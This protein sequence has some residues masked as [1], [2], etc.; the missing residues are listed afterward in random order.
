MFYWAKHVLRHNVSHYIDQWKL[1]YCP[2]NPNIH[3]RLEEDPETAELVHRIQDRLS[4]LNISPSSNLIELVKQAVI[5]QEVVKSDVRKTES[6]PENSPNPNAEGE[7]ESSIIVSRQPSVDKSIMRES[8]EGLEKERERKGPESG[9]GEDE[10]EEDQRGSSH[11]D[12]DQ[13]NSGES[14]SKSALELISP[15]KHASMATESPVS[16]EKHTNEGSTAPTI[17]FLFSAVL[18]KPPTHK[19]ASRQIKPYRGGYELRYSARHILGPNDQPL[20]DL[21]SWM[22]HR[23]LLSVEEDRASNNTITGKEFGL[24]GCSGTISSAPPNPFTATHFEPRIDVKPWFDIMSREIPKR[25]NTVPIRV[26]LKELLY[27]ESEPDPELSSKLPSGALRDDPAGHFPCS[28]GIKRKA[29]NDQGYSPLSA[30]LSSYRS[31]L[32]ISKAVERGKFPEQ[33]LPKKRI[34]Y[35]DKFIVV[36]LP[37]PPPRKHPDLRPEDG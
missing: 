16:Y 1:H 25:P 15:K 20:F 22:T 29:P 26:P 18:S 21:S 33:L 28:D 34:P 31:S 24:G 12:K 14:H 8:L 3:S 27:K 7:T 37:P 35:K 23:D 6:V 30:M 17:D 9:E 10:K 2:E 19:H 4:F 11:G 36:R 13:S 5:L 32:S